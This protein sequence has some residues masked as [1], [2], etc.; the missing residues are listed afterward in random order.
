LKT[1]GGGPYGFRLTTW[2]GFKGAGL[3]IMF[4]LGG[5]L[6]DDKFSIDF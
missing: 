3:F 4:Y 2:R 5:L 6:E 1:N